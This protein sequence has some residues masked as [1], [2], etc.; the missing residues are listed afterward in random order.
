MSTDREMPETTP[1]PDYGHWSDCGVG[2][3][4]EVQL[5][6]T[7]TGTTTTMKIRT[8]LLELTP[9]KARLLAKGSM[10]MAGSETSIPDTEREVPATIPSPGMPQIWGAPTTEGDE[11][12]EVAGE[13][14]LCHWTEARYNGDGWKTVTKMWTC[15]RVPGNVCRIMSR[16]EG[17]MAS[18]TRLAAVAFEKKKP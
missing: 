6:T 17:D 18:E 2:S 16:S 7:V 5:V 11:E 13:K 1:N 12:I 4:V 9:D 14:M 8:T 10:Q 3:F 15:A